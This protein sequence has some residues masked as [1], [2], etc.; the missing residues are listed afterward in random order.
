[1]MPAKE[2]DPMSETAKVPR[3]TPIAASSAGTMQSH[4]EGS[5]VSWNDYAALA[6]VVAAQ[7]DSIRDWRSAY[8]D[9][10]YAKNLAIA[11]LEKQV[12]EE[13]ALAEKWITRASEL[14]ADVLRARQDTLVW[15][16]DE[17]CS[18]CRS[19]I[20]IMEGTEYHEYHKDYGYRKCHATP[21]RRTLEGKDTVE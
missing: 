2:G 20:P 17:V 15:A 13:R 4:P 10:L 14:D 5:W 19:G 12:E 6:E 8:T 21:I 18:R 9:A 3:W 1:M 16:R 7:K 11:E